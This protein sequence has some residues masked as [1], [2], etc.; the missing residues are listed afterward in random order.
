MGNYELEI[1]D[2]KSEMRQKQGTGDSPFVLREESYGKRIRSKK[3]IGQ[4]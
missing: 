4:L 2:W 3:F 1:T